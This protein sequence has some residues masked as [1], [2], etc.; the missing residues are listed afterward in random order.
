MRPPT[1]GESG[2]T[3]GAKELLTS[4][5]VR[6]SSGRSEKSRGRITRLLPLVGG[7]YPAK[8]YGESVWLRVGVTPYEHPEASIMAGSL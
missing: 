1:G 8:G 3:S 2:G 5:V 6:C 4:Y 7:T